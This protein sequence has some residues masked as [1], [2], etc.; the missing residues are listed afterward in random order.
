MFHHCHCKISYSSFR[1]DIIFKNILGQGLTDFAAYAI[2]V[3]NDTLHIRLGI[4]L[5]QLKLY[6]QYDGSMTIFEFIPIYGAGPALYVF[7]FY[8]IN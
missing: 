6:F 4:L 7:E 8:L 1:A 3:D 5:N 2:E